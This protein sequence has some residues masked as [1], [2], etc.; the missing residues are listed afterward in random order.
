MFLIWL[1]LNAILNDSSG[2]ANKSMQSPLSIHFFLCQ[3][4]T[5][6]HFA[7]VQSVLATLLSVRQALVSQVK[8]INDDSQTVWG[9]NIVVEAGDGKKQKN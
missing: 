8:N 9:E 3:F 1:M 7:T 4:L 6:S 2:V 5:S